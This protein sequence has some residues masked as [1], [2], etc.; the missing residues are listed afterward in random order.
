MKGDYHRKLLDYGNILEHKEWALNAYMKA[1]DL[2][3]SK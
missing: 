2:A 1:I 3:C